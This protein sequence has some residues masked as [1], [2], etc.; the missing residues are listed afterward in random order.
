[1][2]G[3]SQKVSEVKEELARQRGGR[4]AGVGTG[5]LCPRRDRCGAGGSVL[6]W[7]AREGALP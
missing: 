1:M 5:V 2:V 6:L 4:V 7:N 3:A